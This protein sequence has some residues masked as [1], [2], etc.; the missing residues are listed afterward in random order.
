MISLFVYCLDRGKSSSDLAMLDI[1]TG[2]FARLGIDTEFALHVPFVRAITSLAYGL[3][4][5][6]HHQEP[7]VQSDV[8]EVPNL[9]ED[10]WQ[11]NLLDA[12]ALMQLEDWS[13]FSRTSPA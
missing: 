5:P 10:F 1:G 7:V 9:G 11:T 2:Y 4:G 13:T 12:D 3:E 8:I 6:T